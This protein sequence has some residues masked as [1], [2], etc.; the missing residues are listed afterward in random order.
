MKELSSP[1]DASGESI[2]FLEDEENIRVRTNKGLQ[3]PQ[4]KIALRWNSKVSRYT[5]FHGVVFI[6]Y[7]GLFLIFL[8]LFGRTA[9]LQD[10]HL[11]YSPAKEVVEYELRPV[12][13][14]A[15]GSIYAGYPNPESDAAWS[16]LVEGINLKIS[17]EE[18]SRLEGSSLA[19]QDG[20]GFL[21]VLGV[22]HELHCIKRLRKW[23]Y[24]DYY[25]PNVTEVEYNERLTHAEHCLEFIRQSAMCHGDITVT[26]FRWL[27][28][29]QGRVVEPTTKEGALHQCVNWDKLSQWAKTRR[30]NLFD[31]NLLVPEKQEEKWR[32]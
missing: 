20:S 11:I 27:H 15:E 18:M 12:D 7:T 9:P 31:K 8:L 21:A 3:Q 17:P 32:H 4:P 14:L 16:A 5:L 22:Y 1:V 28:D 24:R 2:P 25:Y 23:F 10:N 29:A 6:V 13:G 19:M 30:V 26:S